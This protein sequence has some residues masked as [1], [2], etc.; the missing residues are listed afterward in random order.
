MSS[1]MEKKENIVWIGWG[2]VVGTQEARGL[3]NAR[4]SNKS[5]N[6][7]KTMA[8][9]LAMKAFTKQL[10]DKSVQIVSDNISTV[11]Y[12][13]FQGGSRKDLS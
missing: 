2:G 10:Q 13:N 5:S 6:H 11:A 9:L 8:V 4:L 3:W 7:R 1:N 12:I